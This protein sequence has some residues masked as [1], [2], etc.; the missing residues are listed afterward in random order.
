MDREDNKKKF[1]LTLAFHPVWCLHK[2]REFGFTLSNIKDIR[3]FYTLTEDFYKTNI[4]FNNWASNFSSSISSIEKTLLA[5]AWSTTGIRNPEDLTYLSRLFFRAPTWEKF[6]SLKESQGLEDS[7]LWIAGLRVAQS[8]GGLKKVRSALADRL[9]DRY[10]I[11][12]ESSHTSTASSV[13][14]TVSNLSLFDN[15]TISI[16]EIEDQALTPVNEEESDRSETPDSI[17]NELF[18]GPIDYTTVK[19]K[20]AEDQEAVKNFFEILDQSKYEKIRGKLSVTDL[21]S[22]SGTGKD[23]FYDSV[24]SL[25]D[26]DKIF[27]QVLD[28]VAYQ[29]F[30]PEVIRAVIERTW[31]SA[32]DRAH[33]VFF[34]IVL[35]LARGSSIVE[36]AKMSTLKTATAER[37]NKL[38]EALDLH[39]NVKEANKKSSTS[40]IMTLPRICNSYPDIAWR[41]L[42][43]SSLV[44]PI[45][46]DDMIDDGFVGFPPVF[47]GGFIFSIMPKETK[48]W[49]ALSTSKEAIIKAILHYQ[50]KE[51]I[52]LN[53]TTK[54]IHEILKNC[55]TFATAAF[56]SKALTTA[57]RTNQW[58]SIG[59]IV[60][61]VDFSGW[62]SAFNKLHPDDMNIHTSF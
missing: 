22:S 39:K 54:Q 24:K 15:S 36:K 2:V 49:G 34:M 41:V 58:K 56:D 59:S 52:L 7:N 51:H 47:R 3:K 38:V 53:K 45:D 31:P 37:V 57:E 13:G 23:A 28:S 48:N 9:V 17:Y 11:A 62:T 18:G 21:R 1:L 5:F 20:M 35:F 55:T 26:N 43:K 12:S 14:T 50:I 60:K 25:M 16:G 32:V 30:D 42:A 44:R 61:D 27:N 8:E 29:G 10:R 33:H 6:S 40:I 19:P 46:V 4:R